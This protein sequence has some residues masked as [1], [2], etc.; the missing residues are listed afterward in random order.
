VLKIGVWVDNIQYDKDP[1]EATG[2]LR[3]RV[4][5][6][7][8]DN[9]LVP[10]HIARHKVSILGL[11]AGVYG[12]TYEGSSPTTGTLAPEDSSDQ[13]DQGTS[14]TDVPVTIEE[15]TTEPEAT[16]YTQPTVNSFYNFFR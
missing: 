9:D 2:T 7:M 4:S 10:F 6:V 8:R 16:I 12:T 14:L 15:E 5:S 11:N 13:G 1:D 3:Y